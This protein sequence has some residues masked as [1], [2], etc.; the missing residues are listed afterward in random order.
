MDLNCWCAK[1][2]MICGLFRIAAKE[3]SVRPVH[4]ERQKNGHG[5]WN[6]TYSK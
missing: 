3:D 6:K 5:S 4:A 1:D 2:A